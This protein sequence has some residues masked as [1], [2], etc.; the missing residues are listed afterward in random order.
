MNT[1]RKDQLERILENRDGDARHLG[2][3]V[4]PPHP[5]IRGEW[6]QPAPRASSMISSA[7][8]SLTN[9]F[10]D[11]SSISNKCQVVPEHSVEIIMSVTRGPLEI[12]AA[13]I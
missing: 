1:H 2:S 5:V 12:I 3:L 13:A 6:I 10:I 8:N 9:R 7:W 11:P 4:R